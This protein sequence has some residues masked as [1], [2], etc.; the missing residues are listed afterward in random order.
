MNGEKK[1]SLEECI[2]ELTKAM[3]AARRNLEGVSDNNQDEFSFAVWSSEDEAD[4]ENQVSE[5]ARPPE[6]ETLASMGFRDT[7]LNERLLKRMKGN[8]DNVVEK[9]LEMASKKKS[10]AVDSQ[11]SPS[12]AKGGFSSWGRVSPSKASQG[13]H[14]FIFKQLLC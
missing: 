13:M 10:G 4:M 3:E 8:L 11:R 7:D 2:E 6:L 12:I 9:L 5:L 14:L 1:K